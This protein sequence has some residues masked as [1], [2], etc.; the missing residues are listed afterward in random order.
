MEDRAK[1]P[2]RILSGF[3]ERLKYLRGDES[4]PAFAA[5]LGVHKNTLARYEK[6]EGVPDIEFIARIVRMSGDEEVTFN[7]IIDGEG[8]RPAPSYSDAHEELRERLAISFQINSIERAQLFVNVSGVDI[9]PEELLAYISG[10]GTVDEHT[11]ERICHE[12]FFRYEL[13][14]KKRKGASIL[15]K[16]LDVKE[17]ENIDSERIDS[18]LLAESIREVEAAME[19][20]SL[21]VPV[22]KKANLVAL[23]YEEAV[24]SVKR[25]VGSEMIRKIVQLLK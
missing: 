14:T 9:S 24:K 13:V 7:W 21:I 10:N 11:L 1:A 16:S 3:G 22:G 12:V 17:F 2:T 15:E 25:E 19:D 18:A 5:K 8:P 6:E 20:H 4:L 23:A